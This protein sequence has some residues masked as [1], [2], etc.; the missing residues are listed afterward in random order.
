MVVGRL[1]DF[2]YET[3]AAN[4][5]AAFLADPD[6]LSMCRRLSGCKT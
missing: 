3:A 1:K 2:P 5:I 6:L 4:L